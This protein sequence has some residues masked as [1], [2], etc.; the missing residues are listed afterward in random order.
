[1]NYAELKNTDTLFLRLIC[2]ESCDYT[3]TVSFSK[4]LNM[5][6]GKSFVKA[7]EDLPSGLEAKLVIPATSTFTEFAVVATVDDPSLLTER[8]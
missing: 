7:L 3:I 4:E 1:M 8:L 6:L 5:Q 2:L